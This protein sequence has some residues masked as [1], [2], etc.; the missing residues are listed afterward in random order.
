M[1]FTRPGK[2]KKHG[3]L[4]DVPVDDDGR[5]RNCGG[6]CC[7]SFPTVNITWTEYETLRDLGARRLHFSLRGEHRLIIENGCEFLV[8]GRCA[9]YGQRPEVC[10][11]FFCQDD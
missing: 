4:L 9:I 7:R 8:A 11:R 10:R 5:C 1:P 2:T 6:L 3:L